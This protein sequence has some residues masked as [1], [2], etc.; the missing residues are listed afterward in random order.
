M[1]IKVEHGKSEKWYSEHCAICGKKLDPKED[2]KKGHC[3]FNDD[4]ELDFLAC[5]SCATSGEKDGK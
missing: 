2:R 4:E 1:G 5:I 3:I